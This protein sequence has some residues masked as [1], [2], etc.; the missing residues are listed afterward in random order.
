MKEEKN[1]HDDHKSPKAKILREDDG[2]RTPPHHPKG[3]TGEQH[4]NTHPEQAPD[5]PP[6]ERTEGIP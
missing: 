6:H 3:A 2:K 1:Q 4:H 5:V